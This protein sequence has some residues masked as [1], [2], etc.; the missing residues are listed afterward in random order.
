MNQDQISTVK[1]NCEAGVSPSSSRFDVI[2]GTFLGGNLILTSLFDIKVLSFISQS[3]SHCSFFSLGSLRN[4]DDD[5]NKN[6]SNL[7]IWRWK[8]IVLHALHVQFSFLAFRR[9]SRSFCD[10]KLHIKELKQP[11][12]R[13]QQ[14][15]HKFVYLTMKNSIFAR[16]AR[17]LFIFWHFEDVLVLS[18]KMFSFF[19]WLEN[20][21]VDDVSIWWQM[22]NFVLL[23]PKRWFQINSRMVRTHFS[24]IMTLN[25]WKIIAE[26]RSYIFRWCSRFRRRR[27]CLSS[28]FWETAWPLWP[29]TGFFQ[30]VPGSTPCLGLYITNWSASSSLGFLTCSVHL[31][32]SVAVCIVSTRQPMAA[33]Y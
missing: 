17:A 26:T 29:L 2:F 13:L 25:N 1:K 20:S 28:L 4:H 9:R 21:C 31:R 30:V 18:M 3:M 7:H 10:V 27:V 12:P 11:R 22:F 16:F 14:K 32:Y 5:G 15:P 24:G 8:T 33:N 19:L 23:C 6:V